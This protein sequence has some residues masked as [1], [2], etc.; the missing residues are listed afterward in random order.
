MGNA[1]IR[2]EEI[3]QVAL[4]VEDLKKTIERY[5]K[6]LGI[7]PWKIYNCAPPRLKEMIVYGKPTP[8]S[9]MFAETH[10]GQVILEVIEPTEGPSIYKEFLEERGEG[11]HHIACYKVPDVEKTLDNFRK[12]KIG[13]LQSGKFYDDE[14]YYLDT[15]KI[16]GVILEIVKEGKIPPIPDA[17]YPEEHSPTE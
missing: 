11:L 8:Y 6:I 15:E 7:G 12:M 2:F 3:S 1:K 10:L 16:F 5:W 13:V 9:M 17:V 14:F 4:V